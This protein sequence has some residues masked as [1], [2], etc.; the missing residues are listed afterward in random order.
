MQGQLQE[1]PEALGIPLPCLQ[2]HRLW[3]YLLQPWLQPPFRMALWLSL[4]AQ[5]WSQMVAACSHGTSPLPVRPQLSM[6]TLCRWLSGRLRQQQPSS[7]KEKHA[8]G[9]GW[10]SMR[11][12][13]SCLTKNKGTRCSK[14]SSSSSSSHRHSSSI[15]TSLP[16]M[17]WVTML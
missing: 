9:S 14:D 12:R 6:H 4:M 16:T 5:G 13:S 10:R 1:H 7:W 3:L 8:C 11:R 2:L 15:Q 17:L